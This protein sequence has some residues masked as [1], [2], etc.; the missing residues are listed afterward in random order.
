[1]EILGI[2]IDSISIEECIRRISAALAEGRKIRIVTA[3][4]EMI[5][6]SAGNKDLREVINS[7][8]V[9]LPDGVGVLWA[10]RQ[11]GGY[12]PNR[13]TGIDLAQRILEEGNG[14]SWRIFF[15]GAK[16][17]VAEKAAEEQKK[18]YPEIVFGW[19]H[20]YFTKE[21]E[22]ALFREIREFRPDILLT[23]LGVPKQEY[24]NAANPGLAGVVIGVGGS[25]DVLSG[26]V[27]RA[28]DFFRKYNLEWLYRLGSQ[29]S[30][31]KRQAIL[32]LYVLKIL[33]QRYLIK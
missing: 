32:P 16:P 1:M 7:A 5:Y 13:I 23:G 27:K 12:L 33:K 8:D 4:P 3:N 19:H 10:A 24:F 26:E 11:L 9:V 30:R 21:E 6:A 14:Q 28:P 2:Q 20:G 17:G 22:P 25:F 15:L 29:P 18:N 31:L